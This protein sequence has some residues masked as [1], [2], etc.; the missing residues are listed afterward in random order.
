MKSSF[1]SLDPARDKFAQDFRFVPACANLRA[2]R[3]AVSIERTAYRGTGEEW[4][5]EIRN[6]LDRKR[7]EAREE[8]GNGGEGRSIYYWGLGSFDPSATSTLLGTGFEIAPLL[9][10][11]PPPSRLRSESKKKSAFNFP[12][13]KVECPLC[14]Y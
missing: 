1:D 6:I 13:E 8:R 12:A 5:W 2:V 3:I 9:L 14:F 10:S 4:G 11:F 7:F